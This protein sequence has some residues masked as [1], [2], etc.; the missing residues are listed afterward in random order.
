MWYS[1]KI[2]TVKIPQKK[3]NKEKLDEIPIEEIEKYLNVQQN[4]PFHEYNHR[5]HHNKNSTY[6]ISL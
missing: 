4:E 3:T 5:H 1:K 2:D 6:Q